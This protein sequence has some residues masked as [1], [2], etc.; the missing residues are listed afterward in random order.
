MAVPEQTPFIE[1]T[2]NG[3]TTVYPLTFDCDKS[4]Y[5]IVSLDGEEAPVGSWSLA[6]GSITFNSAPANGVL[7][8]IERNTPFRR[9]TEYQSYNNSFRPSPVNKDFDLIWWKLQEL[10]Y[11]DQ[12]IWL[13]LVKEIA[14]RI[15][16]DDNLQS[17][18]NTIDEWLANLQQNVNENT[19]DIAQLVEDLSREIADRITNDEALKEMFLAMM[20]EAINE[21][22]INALAITHVDSLSDLEN[23][24]N[25][26]EGRTIFVKDL[27]NYEYK[28]SSSSW[29]KSYQSSAN[30][31]DGTE[32]QEQI[33]NKTIQYVDSVASLRSLKPRHNY[34]VAE[35]TSFYSDTFSG[36]NRF[37]WDPANTTDDNGY[38]IIKVNN[39][40]IGRWR[41]IDDDSITSSQVGVRDSSN[42]NQ[43]LLNKLVFQFK[44]FKFINKTIIDDTLVLNSNDVKYTG[45]STQSEI[46]Y[47]GG[48]G[49]SGALK[50]IVKTFKE[51]GNAISNIKLSDL[52][53]AMNRANYTVGFDARYLT[54]ESLIDRLK[55]IGIADTSVGIYLTKC[56]Y[57]KFR[58]CMVSGYSD[59]DA[60]NRH[61][62]GIYIDSLIANGAQVNAVEF[63]V[64]CHSLNYGYLINPQ[65]Y[66]YGLNLLNMATIENCNFG[67]K[68]KGS[69]ADLSVRQ[70][71]I[72]QYFENNTVDIEWGDETNQ[73]ALAS[74][75]TWL[76]CSFDNVHSTIKLWEGSHVFIGCKGVVNLTIGANASVRFV[77]TPAPTGVIT[78]LGSD[79]YFV[80]SNAKTFI[81]SGTYRSGSLPPGAMFKRRFRTTNTSTT[82]DISKAFS[83]APFTE[84]QTAEIRLTSRRDYDFDVKE[85]RGTLWRKPDG[86]SFLVKLSET[87]GLTVSIVGDI[88]TVGDGRG[89]SKTYE[90]IMHID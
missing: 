11:R 41:M 52:K 38:S 39:I 28:S 64:K 6:G 85:W 55:I 40:S 70:S 2:A 74:Q 25:V 69:T 18:I 87:T 80:E 15:A 17:Q 56:W 75:H 72:S 79:N 19:N 34:A 71:V 48:A 82:F 30:V 22:T 63:D 46:F 37:K 88:L 50:S 58:Q 53:I 5:L 77:N 12:V 86:N 51:N 62:I 4:E 57:S 81:T 84:G 49:A 59:L 42:S 60:P 8:T 68:V 32:N 16:G 78:N 35:T 9:T 29:I 83:S 45:S 14:D 23:V 73:R 76:S 10:G 89:D 36:R 1:Y 24:T 21:G 61:G 90:L 43:L 31:I 3:T 66:I 20:D 47:A 26:W 67:I 33:N 44:E 27:G 7:I 65:N 13:A 54:N